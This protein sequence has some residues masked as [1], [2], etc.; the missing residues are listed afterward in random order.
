MKNMN[1]LLELASEH[2]WFVLLVSPFLLLA[3]L[4]VVDCAFL[5]IS[6]VHLMSDGRAV[7]SVASNDTVSAA[8]LSTRY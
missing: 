6:G 3:C 8:W 7:R 1:L 5:L 2:P 4:I